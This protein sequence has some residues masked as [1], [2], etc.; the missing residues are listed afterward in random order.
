MIPSTRLASQTRRPGAARSSSARWALLILCSAGTVAATAAEPPGEVL[1]LTNWRLT[2][3]VDGDR[4]GRA[5]EVSQPELKSFLD[6][7]FFFVPEESGV[8]LFRAPCGG[9]TTKGSDYPRCE[10]REM[11]DRG[12]KRVAW[13]TDDG[14]EHTLTMRVAIVRTPPVKRHVVCAQIH[15]ANDDVMMVR[16]EGRKLFV[17]R[18]RTGDVSL[19]ADHELGRPFELKI[20][21]RAGRIKVWYDRRQKMDWKQ[22]RSGCYFKAGCYTQSHPGKGDAADSAGEVRIDRLLVRHAR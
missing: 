17:E 5:D 3:P 15:D 19:D 2:L 8:V 22:S 6:R 9:A 20:Q 7:R 14:M 16:L 18:N 12:R 1:D 13:G 4:D 21:A 10:L 11:T